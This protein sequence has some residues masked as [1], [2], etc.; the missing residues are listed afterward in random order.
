VQQILFYEYV[1]DVLER[2]APYREEH[3]ER[4]HAARADG[5]IVMAGA[6]GNPP[7]GAVL[8]FGDIEREQVEAF[9]RDDPYVQ[10]GLVTDWRIESLNVV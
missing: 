3:L 7:H 5:R 10:S 2:R 8:V 4:I 6:L 1:R 9:A